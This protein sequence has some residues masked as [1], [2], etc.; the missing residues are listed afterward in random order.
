MPPKP[1][2]ANQPKPEYIIFI[3]GK[4]SGLTAN[5]HKA[6]GRIADCRQTG[7]VFDINKNEIAYFKK[8]E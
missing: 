4:L 7:H 5:L 2:H 1:N 3:D 6:I 8:G